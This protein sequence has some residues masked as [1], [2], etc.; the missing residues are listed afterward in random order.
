MSDR[1]KSSTFQRLVTRRDCLRLGVLGGLG[2]TLP[3]LLS[4]RAAGNSNTGPSLGKARSCILL[5]MYGGPAHQDIWDLK[6]NGPTD[7][8]GE[9]RPISTSVPGCQVSEHIP[10]LAKQAHRY[11]IVRSATHKDSVHETA[12]YNMVTGRAR[13]PQLGAAA[14]FDDHPHMG[15]IVSRLVKSDSPFSTF[16]TTRPTLE[17]GGGEQH[18]P[19][20]GPGFL[21]STFEPTV[22]YNPQL[23]QPGLRFAG[24]SLPDDV[25]PERF[26][27][28]R[29]LLDSLNQ[30]PR[31]EDPTP[32]LNDLDAHQQRAAAL[33]TSSAA[34]QALDL[35]REPA[36]VRQRYGMTQ[37]G[38]HLLLARRLV[39]AGVRSSRFTTT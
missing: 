5:F 1:T 24:L 23:H 32:A 34:R 4:G 13:N 14:R 15:S 17:N 8:P 30:L 26:D 3:E 11:S 10:Y 20:L 38:Q 25:T 31:P 22:L 37:Y 12:F 2:L 16:V 33:L 21:G 18:Y 6:A 29:C 27:E 28:R 19:G 35:S 39:E 36:S 7:T 9:F